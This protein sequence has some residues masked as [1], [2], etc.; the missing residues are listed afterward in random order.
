MKTILTG[1]L[2]VV[3]ALLMS[4][5]T[6]VSRAADTFVAL[7]DFWLSTDS[8][9]DRGTVWRNADF[10]YYLDWP[11]GITEMGF[12]D[13]DEFTE[14]NPAPGG[15]P[16]NTA[17]FMTTF[18]VGSTAHYSN[19]S[20]RLRRDDGAVVYINGVEVFRSNM[21]TGEV[22]YATSALRDLERAEE[23]S[24]VQR[25]VPAS[26]LINGENV[27]AVE[28]HQAA[29]ESSDLS[30]ALILLGHRV[31]ENQPPSAFSSVVS[32]QQEQS[33]P[34]ALNATDP[35]G[36]PLNY[37]LLSLPQHGSLSGT[38]PNVTFTPNAGYVGSDT[39][40]F[41]AN[42]GQWDTEV[43][44]VFIEVTESSNHAPVAN[45]QEV[46]AVEDNAL[47]ITLTATDADG[48]TL[49]FSHS[50]PTHGT[51]T[52]GSGD[53]LLYHPDLN[54]SGPDSF[55]FTVDDGHGGTAT[56]TVSITVNPVNDVPVALAGAASASAPAN[57]TRHLV[58]V[59]GDGQN[60]SVLL[61]SSG[62]SDVESALAY[63]W[64]AG[65]SSTPLSTEANP[66]V[67]L[68]PGSYTIIL[69]VS[70]GSADA[71]DAI[72]VQILTPSALVQ[73]LA[74]VV[75]SVNLKSSER[76][77]L[78]GHLNAASSHFANGNVNAALH[79]LEQF[80]ARVNKKVT[81]PAVAPALISAAQQIIEQLTGQ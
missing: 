30:F 79:Q 78:L 53:A 34:I 37:T 20:V 7:N 50:A 67:S 56:A 80:Q 73:S 42:D 6:N 47:L 8:G 46:L 43:A 45:A 25:V 52:A 35:D 77:G 28:V 54:Y 65:S 75:Q 81:D 69:V 74:A 70:D 61:N 39:F 64:Y 76:G 62:S 38:P 49:T 63:A 13:G 14:L 1:V 51:L 40:S 5:L 33:V 26:V 10:G 21:P 36:N 59:V 18:S 41:M 15:V 23:S 58:I 55:T 66:T 27:I 68:P 4:V 72:T 60:A 19:L 31:N 12:G 57:F 71:S 29:G 32:T 2:T 3:T 16:L 9:I 44:E 48:D 17:Y 11:I 24:L 22:S